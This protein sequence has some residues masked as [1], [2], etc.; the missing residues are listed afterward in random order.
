MLFS[1][2]LEAILTPQERLKIMLMQNFVVTVKEHFGMLYIVF[3]GVV[4]LVL[5]LLF[6]VLAT[7]SLSRFLQKLCPFRDWSNLW[8]GWS[9]LILHNSVKVGTFNNLE[10][11]KE[12][13]LNESSSTVVAFPGRASLRRVKIKKK[14]KMSHR[15]RFSLVNWNC[16]FQLQK[17]K[18]LTYDLFQ[19]ILS[20]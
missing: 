4:I 12:V 8:P 7:P 17:K 20:I 13:I 1:V 18:F 10:N 2:S 11:C 9:I 14:L 5:L 3:S 15:I 6:D 16:Q 19:L